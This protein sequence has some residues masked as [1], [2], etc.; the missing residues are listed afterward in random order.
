MRAII[1]YSSSVN[2][3]TLFLTALLVSGVLFCVPASSLF[4]APA[5]DSLSGDAMPGPA[6]AMLCKGFLPP[7]DLSIPVDSRDASGINE[8]Q[9]NAVLDSLDR[10]YA[11]IVAQQGGVLEIRRFWTDAT[12]NASAQRLGKNYVLNMY[13]GLA[14]HEAI[15]MDGFALVACHELGHHLGGAPKMSGTWATNEGQ[16]DYYANLKCLRMVFSYSASSDFSRSAIGDEV[17]EKG[18]EQQF[19][20]AAERALCV[21]NALAGKSLATLLMALRKETVEPRFDT[22][23]PAV[24]GSMLDSHPPTQCRL[25][26]YLQGALCTQPAAAGLSDTDPAI[27]TCT[28]SG[29]FT[30][31]FRPLCWYKP[32]SPDEALPLLSAYGN[33]GADGSPAAPG[34]AFSVLQSKNPWLGF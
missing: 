28:R 14:R 5:A 21:R 17:A 33:A 26:T 11:P 19:P 27:G 30:A 1:R 9:F 29:G 22:P 15:T 20:D 18:C 32:S 13:G 12:V 24:A 3:I 2:P 25:D 23:D 8:E 7:N 16:A 31:G 10:L 4:A 6:D 34:P